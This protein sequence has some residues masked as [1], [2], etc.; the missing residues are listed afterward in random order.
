MKTLVILA[1]PNISESGSQQFLLNS[2]EQFENVTVHHLDRHY[3]DGKIDRQAEQELLKK[4]Q[5]IIFQ[6][7]FYWYSSPSILKEWQDVVFAGDDFYRPEGTI[8][9]GK[10][11]G[12]V[13]TIGVSESEYRAG[14]RESFTVDELTRPYQAV[15]HHM[16]MSYLPH[17]SIHQFVYLS[18]RQQ[19]QLLI[20]YQ[21]YLTGL[22]PASLENRTNWIIQAL[23][24]TDP[25]SLPIEKRARLEAIITE[26]S[27]R[28]DILADLKATLTEF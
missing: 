21:F 25:K 3:P 28:Q 17:F 15:A 26:L 8:L 16:G 1:H 5:R 22:Q 9:K 10:E 24:T 11:F 18:E 13:L 27:E 4:H 12:L 20:D 23:K 7:P 6:F 2:V 19:Q 14:G